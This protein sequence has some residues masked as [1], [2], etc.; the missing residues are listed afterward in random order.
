MSRSVIFVSSFPIPVKFLKL[1][2]MVSGGILY[3][4]GFNEMIVAPEINIITKIIF[5]IITLAAIN[6]EAETTVRA[7]KTRLFSDSTITLVS[8]MLS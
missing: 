5:V 2:A 8:E 4:S 6:L 3:L 1:L 7:L